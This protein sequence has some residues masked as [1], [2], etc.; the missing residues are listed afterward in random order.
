MAEAAGTAIGIISFGLQLYTGLSEYLDAVKGREEDLLQAKNNAKTLQC[1]LKAIGDALSKVNGSSMAQDAVEECKSSCESE[2]HALNSLLNDLLGKPINSAGPICKAKS[3]MQKWSYPFKKKNIARVEERLKSANNVLKTALSA[4]QLAILNDQ[5][6]AIT[7]LQQT[8]KTILVQAERTSGTTQFPNTKIDEILAHL[9]NEETVKTQVAQLVSYPNDLRTLCDAVS[10]ASLRSEPRYPP[11][12][13]QTVGSNMQRRRGRDSCNCAKRRDVQRSRARLGLISL[14]TELQK[15]THHAPECPLSQIVRSTQQKRSAVGVS[16]PSILNVLTS[17]VGISISLTTGAGG[18]S[19]AQNITWSP[20]V[21][22][23]LSPAFKLVRALCALKTG[24]EP[25]LSSEHYEMIAE[26]CVRRL[27]LC[28]AKHEASP[29]DMNGDGE[30]VLDIFAS[31]LSHLQPGL[32]KKPGDDVAYVFRS[33]A[34]IEVP[35][36]YDRGGELQFLA[37]VLE[38]NWLLNTSTLPDT[39]SAL[40]SR[41]DESTRHDYGS[42]YGLD[43]YPRKRKLLKEFPEIA[44]Y[45]G[46]NPL[47]VAILQENEEE[48]EFL[49]RKYPSYGLEINYCGQ[50]PVHIAV[51]VGNL[52]IFS[53][54]MGRVNL[55]ALS[56][57][58][59]ERRYPID[60]AISHLHKKPNLGDQQLCISCSMVELLL[61]AKS[62]L[63]ERSLELGLRNPCQRTKTAVLQHLA[64]R[65]KELEQLA[66]SELP[67]EDVRGFGLCKGWIL[68]RHASQVQCCLE[69]RSCDV[70]K[71]VMVHQKSS[72]A[73]SRASSKSIYAYILDRETAEYAL[74]LGFDK[75]TAFID[76][77]H[78]IIRKVIRRRSIGWPSPWYIDWII[79]DSGDMSSAVPSDFMPGVA[80]RVTWA[81]YLMAI[82]GYK[83]RYYPYKLYD[84]NLPSSVATAALSDSLCDDCRCHCSLHGC[85]PVIKFLEGL[86]C[87]R[88][89]PRTSFTL[90]DN[91]RSLLASIQ[92]L[93]DRE[94]EIHSWMPRAILRYSTFCAL[95]LRHTCCNLA[96]GGSCAEMNSDDIDEIHDED[97]DMLQLLEELVSDFGDGYGSLSTLSTF[98]QE[99]WL[100]K[101]EEVYRDINHRKL[102]EAEL[103]QAEDY[104]VKLESVE[105][106]PVLWNDLPIGLEGWMRRLDD[107]AADPE[108]PVV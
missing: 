63:F 102:T 34:A 47:S 76:A 51:L 53:L 20:T 103:K 70:P 13:R 19:L 105:D 28:Y 22:E 36:T 15:T 7:S 37:L 94:D 58:D 83:A 57:A 56:I 106:K 14:E 73:E 50:S 80:Q 4:L 72:S 59:S 90:T 98:L 27:Q 85:T 21:D 29:A 25:S 2:L 8:M 92:D 10:N 69:T 108:R 46:F 84:N 79:R 93:I 95:G 100:P 52:R 24:L 97:S 48:V 77:F 104:G 1:S 101:M 38:S 31:Q 5:S 23:S 78:S 26:S 81:H 45:L 40:L 96:N 44:Q 61:D 89:Y 35:V 91:A 71:D 6:T 66:I 62:P 87:R 32:S 39:V 16:V 30:S 43:K 75:A 42:V 9:R 74:S 3:S 41:C 67:M 88:R 99:V 86:G 49:S 68:D 18:F 55:E 82:L 33:L 54:L 11:P 65:R 64:Q 17:A 60:Y 12:N 107:I